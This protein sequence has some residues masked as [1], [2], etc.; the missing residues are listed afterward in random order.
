MGADWWSPQSAAAMAE[1]GHPHPHQI[2]LNP[3]P[4]RKWVTFQDW[5]EESGLMPTAATVITR[6]TMARPV[7][8]RRHS[9]SG[10]EVTAAGPW[11]CLSSSLS[12]ESSLGSTGEGRNTE[13]AQQKICPIEAEKDASEDR[14]SVEIDY[15]E[16]EEYDEM[17][18]REPIF[19]ASFGGY[20][21]N[22]EAAMMKTLWQPPQRM[23]RLSRFS[24]GSSV[25]SIESEVASS[26]C[27]P[28]LRT[29]SPS[30]GSG[31]SSG[32]ITTG[33]TCPPPRLPGLQQSSP[34][35]SAGSEPTHWLKFTAFDE[36]R[37][38][39][40]GVAEAEQRDSAAGKKIYLLSMTP[41]D[42]FFKD[43]TSATVPNL[44]QGQCHEIFLR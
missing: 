28:T 17:Q 13:G 23:S 40:K 15:E 32:T 25:S 34:Q 8:T 6:P 4:T 42:I 10:E 44:L 5:D 22:G 27:S 11:S 41:K 7:V 3:P 35:S 36:V 43:K 29:T 39:E 12:S 2:L 16:I 31:G 14:N 18:A 26:S 33:I 19:N 37:S 21:L 9:S 24:M 20:K 1:E 30:S 38:F